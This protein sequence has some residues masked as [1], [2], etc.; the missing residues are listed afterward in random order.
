MVMIQLA[1]SPPRPWSRMTLGPEPASTYWI[2][3]PKI[4]TCLGD[5]WAHAETDPI[6]IAKPSAKAFMRCSLPQAAE[7]RGLN[8]LLR[9]FLVPV[10]G[11]ACDVSLVRI[12]ILQAQLLDTIVVLADRHGVESPRLYLSV[13]L[14]SGQDVQLGGEGQR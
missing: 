5:V 8:K 11:A 9:V 14:R 13:Q 1:A 12:E 7:N 6:R 4:S 10:D 2:F 3:C